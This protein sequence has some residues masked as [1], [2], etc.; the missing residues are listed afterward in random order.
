MITQGTFREDLYYRLNVIQIVVPPLRERRDDIPELVSHFLNKF[1][2][3]QP[4]AD[5]RRLARGDEGA[6]A[7]TP[8]PATSA[9]SRT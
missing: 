9:S 6:R 7:P 2:A 5:H 3:R 4:L 1:V 8:G